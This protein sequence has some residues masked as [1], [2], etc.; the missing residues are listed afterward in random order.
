MLIAFCGID[1]AGKTTLLDR[2]EKQLQKDNKVF[3]TKQPTD[4]YKQDSRFKSFI[5]GNLEKNKFIVEE[6]ALLAATDRIRH[7]NSEIMPKIEQGYI[8]LTDRYVFSSYSYMM[9][10]GIKDLKW[11]MQINK[12]APNPD[13]TFYIDVPAEVAIKR[14]QERDGKASKEEMNIRIMNQVREYFLSQPWGKNKTDHII[15]NQQ[16]II[17]NTRLILNIIK[18][19][20][21]N[22]RTEK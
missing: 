9:A 5:S 8:V 10:R 16:S 4:W 14:I 2:V 21:T 17:K 3:R 1:G 13:L 7:I 22:W 11:L 20:Q 15:D 12:F 19:Y 18:H 6:L